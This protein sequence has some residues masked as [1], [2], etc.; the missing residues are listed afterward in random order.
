MYYQIV[1]GLHATF[2]S[3]LKNLENHK[4]LE[5]FSKSPRYPP[6]I[7]PLLTR[8]NAQ[9]IARRPYEKVKNY[10]I[11]DGGINTMALGQWGARISTWC[12]NTGS[13]SPPKLL[14][15]QFSLPNNVSL[16][17]SYFSTALTLC[18]GN[19]FLHIKTKRSFDFSNKNII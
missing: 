8:P 13:T 3:T 17:N 10:P 6:T 2:W 4:Y 11:S 19:L 1:Q 9:Q 14:L 15:V 7:Q 5:I 18:F 12:D 16:K